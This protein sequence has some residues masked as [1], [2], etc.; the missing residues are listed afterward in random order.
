MTELIKKMNHSKIL[1]VKFEMLLFFTSS[2]FSTKCMEENMNL[3]IPFQNR[4][5]EIEDK[6]MVGIAGNDFLKVRQ[7]Y[8]EIDL[9]LSL[10][11]KMF[12]YVW[13]I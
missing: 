3:K 9:V 12:I 1:T 2:H 10:N 6:C 13:C 4:R 8:K 7:E 11:N 5:K